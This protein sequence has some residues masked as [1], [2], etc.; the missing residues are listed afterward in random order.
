[1][2]VRLAAGLAWDVVGE[3]ST[4]LVLFGL[5][6]VPEGCA[7]GVWLSAKTLL[8]Y[9]DLAMALK[10]SAARNFLLQGLHM[11]LESTSLSV[12]GRSSTLLSLPGMSALWDSLENSAT[13]TIGATALLQSLQE[14]FCI[15][16]VLQA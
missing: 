16:A 7:S 14:C 15:E 5:F 2:V 6:L 9:A 3:T 11:Y 13:E 12:I 10:L 4:P 8:S 1:M